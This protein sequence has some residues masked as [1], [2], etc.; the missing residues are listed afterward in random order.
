MKNDPTYLQGVP[1]LIVL[2]GRHWAMLECKRSP[3]AAK[4]PNQEYYVEMLD[5][6]SFATF[7]Y[8]ENKEDVLCELQQAFSS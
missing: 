8:P 6:W 5:Q 4:Q 2:W 1:D 7:I 3:N